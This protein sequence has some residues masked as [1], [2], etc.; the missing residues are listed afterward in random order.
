MLA[1]VLLHKLHIISVRHKADVLA[2]VLAG[3]DEVHTLGQFAHVRLGHTAQRKQHMSQLVLRQVVEHIALI[4][5]R[6]Q[7]F[8]Q[9]PAAVFARFNAGVVAGDHPFIAVLQGII[10]QLVELHDPVAVDAGIGGAAR[11][12]GAHKFLNDG[13][14]EVHGKIQN[15]IGNVQLK[16]HGGRIVNV[17]LRAAGVKL[18]QADVLIAVQAHGG[19]HAVVPPT[20]HQAGGYRTVHAAAHGD[21]GFCFGCDGVHVLSKNDETAGKIAAGAKTRKRSTY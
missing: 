21:E 2:V 7:G 20:L 17:F 13:L 10:Q 14:P 18:P 9:K 12:I 19:P 16:G 6:V 11:L 3:V 5:G 4:L 1:G 15:F 8:F